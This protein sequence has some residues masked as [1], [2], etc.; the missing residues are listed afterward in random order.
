M[1]YNKDHHDL[2]TA[3]GMADEVMCMNEGRFFDPRLQIC[4]VRDSVPSDVI[5]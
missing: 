5:V 4:Q 3:V 1:V 2:K